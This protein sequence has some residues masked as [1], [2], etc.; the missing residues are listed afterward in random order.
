MILYYIKTVLVVTESIC[1]LVSN[2]VQYNKESVQYP[3]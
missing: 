3:G 2:Q 1:G